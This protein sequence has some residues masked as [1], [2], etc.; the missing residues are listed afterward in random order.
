MVRDK[1]G[2][3]EGDEV[4]GTAS[5]LRAWGRAGARRKGR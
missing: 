2:G 1:V 5:P 4:K 3:K